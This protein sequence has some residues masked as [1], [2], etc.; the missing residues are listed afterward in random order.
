VAQYFI[1]RITQLAVTFRAK[2]PPSSINGTDNILNPF[3]TLKKILFSSE[4]VPK[5]LKAT[6]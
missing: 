4:A 5:L 3:K 1:A 6:R 2:L